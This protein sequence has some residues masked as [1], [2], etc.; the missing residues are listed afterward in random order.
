MKTTGLT[1]LFVTL[2]QLVVNTSV[3]VTLP[4][5]NAATHWCTSKKCSG[6]HGHPLQPHGAWYNIRSCVR[7][8]QCAIAKGRPSVIVT[9]LKINQ[10]LIDIIF[11]VLLRNNSTAS[12][13]F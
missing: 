10:W 12:S 7:A 1:L 13:S 9:I 11:T 5:S 2:R 6:S 3:F 8:T 4:P